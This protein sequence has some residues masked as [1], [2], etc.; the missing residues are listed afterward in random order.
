MTNQDTDAQHTRKEFLPPFRP[1]IEAAE[2]REVIDTLES[3]WITTGPK[4]HAF[5]EQFKDYVGTRFAVAVNSCTAA[6]HLS[7]AASGIGPGDE[8]ITSP[9][10]FVATANVII[11]QGAK[12]TFADIDSETHN[13]SPE[14]VEKNLTEQTKA[15]IPVHYAGHPCEMDEIDHIAKEHDLLVIEDAAHALGASYK[16]RTV[17]TLGD[18]TCFSFYATKNITT[19]EGGMLTTNDE[20][21]AEKARIL[22]LHGISKDAWTRYSA[23]GS[24]YYEVHY[25]GYK[26]NMTDIQAAIGTHQLK[27]LPEMQKR[28]EEIAYAYNDAFR[29]TDQII[30]PTSKAYIRNA[31]HLY[32]I[33][34]NTDVLSADRNVVIDALK[35][36]NIGTSVHF[37]PVHLH[38][39][40]RLQYGYKRGDFPYA[41]HFFDRMISLPLY[42][43]M[44]DDDVEDVITAVKHVIDEYKS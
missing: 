2:I 40:Y 33:Q 13:I 15:I 35:A 20:Q 29:D 28:R 31:W 8:V 1:F 11:H 3:D 7:L 43:R 6:L 4:T 12:P 25:P 23:G 44:K 14:S 5:E 18:A 19:A 9:L 39:Y 42:P 17:G 41:E 36:R 21:L 27:K 26:Y 16:N 34:I 24:W 10:T 37:I 22:S 32:A 30:P 38:P